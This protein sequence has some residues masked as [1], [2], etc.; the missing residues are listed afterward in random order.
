MPPTSL[1][2]GGFGQTDGPPTILP[3]RNDSLIMLCISVRGY[4]NNALGT[5]LQSLTLPELQ[6]FK[7]TLHEHPEVNFTVDFTPRVGECLRGLISQ[8]SFRILSLGDVRMDT[9][10]L[11]QLLSSTPNLEKLAL[12]ARHIHVNAIYKSYASKVE[13]IQAIFSQIS[14][15]SYSPSQRKIWQKILFYFA[16]W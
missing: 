14:Q 9:D 13:I 1:P 4:P 8:K 11:I 3:V 2:H 5:M 10:T 12:D 15:S 16:Q 6:G 7:L